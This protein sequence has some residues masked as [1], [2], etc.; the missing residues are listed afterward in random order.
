[1]YTVEHLVYNVITP[2]N[3]VN[4]PFIGNNSSPNDFSV[5]TSFLSLDGMLCLH[6]I[7]A[8]HV[9]KTNVNPRI[10]FP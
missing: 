8:F 6:N 2:R 4:I 3:I 5:I 1:M 10:M 7:H 9:V